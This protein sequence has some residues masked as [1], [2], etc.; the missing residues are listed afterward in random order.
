M[1]QICFISYTSVS[2]FTAVQ[3]KRF[4]MR[5]ITMFVLT[6]TPTPKTSSV[7]PEPAHPLL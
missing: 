3:S 7:N 5:Q 1:L 6:V 4:N 2:L